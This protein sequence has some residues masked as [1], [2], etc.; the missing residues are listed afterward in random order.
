MDHEAEEQQGSDD[1]RI[2]WTRRRVLDATRQLLVEE[3]QEAV[4]PT[5]LAEM[6]GVSRSTIYRR[7]PEP[8]DIIF[9]AIADDTEAPPFTPSGGIR[10]DLTRYLEALREGLRGSHTGLL[11]TRIDRAEHDPEVAKMLRTIAENRRVLIAD[12][13][14]HPREEFSEAQALIVGP[15]MYQRFLARE[16]ITD[17][18]I[19][20]IVDAYMQNRT[21]L[22]E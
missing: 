6:T 7:W 16:E 4:T 12:L 15:L 8:N 10:Q 14:E 11:A 9:E 22:S 1:P 5:R 13:L 17:E 19:E 20:R 3:G 18:L 21:D 2:A